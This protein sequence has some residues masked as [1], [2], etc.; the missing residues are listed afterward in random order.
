MLVVQS[1]PALCD[2][3]GCSWPGSSVHGIL[4]ARMLEW[5]AILSRGSSQPR[6]PTWVSC[7]AGRLYHL[8]HQGSPYKQSEIQRNQMACPRACHWERAGP[9][10]NLHSFVPKACVLSTLLPNPCLE[11]GAQRLESEIVPGG[12]S[13]RQ[14]REGRE[15]P[16]VNDV[17][18]VEQNLHQRENS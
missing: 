12:R 17:H 16:G 11:T 15:N 4:Q 10:L 5:V 6:D 14:R 2:L 3:T 1:C 7:I 13:W 8:N 18:R 9:K